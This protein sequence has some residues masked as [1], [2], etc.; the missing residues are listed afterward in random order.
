MKVLHEN[1]LLPG[2]DK[3]SNLSPCQSCKTLSASYYNRAKVC[4]LLLQIFLVLKMILKMVPIL[5]FSKQAFL[6]CV[7]LES[8]CARSLLSV[9]YPMKYNVILYLLMRDL[10]FFFVFLDVNITSYSTLLSLILF[11]ISSYSFP[12]LV[13]LILL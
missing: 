5:V 7:S 1:I 10:L 8:C 4:W 11:H 9:Q 2:D 6:F 3:D 13:T 12:H